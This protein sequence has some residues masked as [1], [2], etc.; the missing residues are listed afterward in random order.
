M[1]IL[2]RGQCSRIHGT[3]CAYYAYLSPS[4]PSKIFT[5]RTCKP[6]EGVFQKKV[7]PELDHLERCGFLHGVQH[8]TINIFEITMYSTAPLRTDGRMDTT[9]YRDATAH[10]KIPVTNLFLTQNFFPPF[11]PSMRSTFPTKWRWP[12]RSTSLTLASTSCFTSSPPR[13]ITSNRWTLSS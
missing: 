1:F 2:A 12:V 3:R 13:G 11:I 9:S 7:Y 4:E 5:R 6:H 10:L 8:V